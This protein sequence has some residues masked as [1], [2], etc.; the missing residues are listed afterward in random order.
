MKRDRIDLRD[1]RRGLPCPGR[2]AQEQVVMG[3]DDVLQEAGEVAN[4]TDYF[5]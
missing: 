2:A 4:M 3:L 1:P 5:R